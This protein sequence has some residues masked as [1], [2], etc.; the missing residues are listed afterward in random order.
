M[1]PAEA[2][3]R[4]KKGIDRLGREQYLTGMRAQAE[5]YGLAEFMAWQEKCLVEDFG[6]P[7][8]AAC[9]SR[10][11]REYVAGLLGMC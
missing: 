7:A 4:S 11:F 8:R 9:N 2:I 10:E 3:E 1:T 5:K 6:E